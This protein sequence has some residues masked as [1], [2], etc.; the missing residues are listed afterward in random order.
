MQNN[1]FVHRLEQTAARAHVSVAGLSVRL[2]GV[3][4]LIK[5]VLTKRSKRGKGLLNGT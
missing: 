5:S 3:S 1:A 2:S 4:P